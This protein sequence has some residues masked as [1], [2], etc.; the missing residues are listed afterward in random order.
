MENYSNLYCAMFFELALRIRKFDAEQPLTHETC[1]ESTIGT[2]CI[3][4]IALHLSAF[5]MD[6]PD[7]EL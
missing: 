5:T 6:C 4:S 7:V 3:H 1:N 2:Q